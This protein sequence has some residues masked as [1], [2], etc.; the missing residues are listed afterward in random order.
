VVA[1]LGQAI[2]RLTPMALDAIRGGLDALQIAALAGWTAFSIYAEGYRAFQRQ[3]SPRVVARARYLS[4]HPR[5]LH[6]VLAPAYCM[7]LLHATKKRLVVSWIVTLAIIGIVIVVRRL[8]QPWRGI[9]DAGV[10]AALVWGTVAIVVFAA[11][12][13]PLPVSPDVP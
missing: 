10:V 13:G 6:V 3:F 5:P 7:G 12:R 4:A 11:R 8:D 2:Y 9:I 1:L